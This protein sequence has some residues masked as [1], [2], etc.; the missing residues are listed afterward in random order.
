MPAQETMTTQLEAINTMLACVGETPIDTLLGSLTANVQI[1]VNQLK[2]TS[3]ELQ[4]GSWHFN[5]EDDY[6]LTLDV[7]GFCYLP[8]NTLDVDLHQEDGTVDLVQRGLQLYDKKNHTFVFTANPKV[9]L[10]FFL[11]WDELN[12][13]TRNYIKIRAARQLQD[14][15]VG[16]REHHQYFALDES[17]AYT[18]FVSADT[19][20][21]D[22]TI[23][24]NWDIASIVTRRRPRITAF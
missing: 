16:S 21:E 24:D 22:A 15:T 13:P 4:S 12:E 10:T 3:R 8:G 14:R 17:T 20:N 7:N 23:F 9:D 19:R 6:E 18:N 2:D 11:T 5:S 1:A